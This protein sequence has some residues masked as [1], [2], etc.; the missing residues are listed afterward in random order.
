MDISSGCEA[1][2]ESFGKTYSGNMTNFINWTVFY[3]GAFNFQELLILGELADAFH[4]QGK[5]VNF[6]DV[7]ANIGHH[8]LK[9]FKPGN[10]EEALIL[11]AELAGI[12]RDTKH[13]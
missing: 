3:Y 12:I 10:T 5:T 11:P 7:G 4:A 9:P 13:H 2:T 6:F 1:A 8:T